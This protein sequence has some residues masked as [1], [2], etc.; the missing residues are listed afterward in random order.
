MLPGRSARKRSNWPSPRA[1]DPEMAGRAAAIALPAR[2]VAGVAPDHDLAG[3]A[4]GDRTRRADRQRLY[5]CRCR[6]T[7][8]DAIDARIRP[9][10]TGRR[11]W[12]RE[13]IGR[14]ASSP[15]PGSAVQVGQPPRDCRPRP[16]SGRPRAFPLRG[17]QRPATRHP[18]RARDSSLR[19][20]C[21]SAAGP[22]R[23][24]AAR[25]RDRL[26][27]Q[28]RWYPG[29]WLETDSSRQS[30]ALQS[31]YAKPESGRIR[32]AVTLRKQGSILPHQMATKSPAF[33]SERETPAKT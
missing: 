12:Q 32:A 18:A 17:R 3:R 19:P 5:L 29:E 6:G 23:P 7:R 27:R 30:C 15:A 25:S 16:A 10:E 28:R 24:C 20:D 2:R 33:H 26:R 31:A 13:L 1:V 9:G 8:R 21:W 11:C 14:P 4:K 22:G